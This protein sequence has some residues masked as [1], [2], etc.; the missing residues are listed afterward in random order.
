MRSPV[1]SYD[2][3]PVPGRDGK[4]IGNGMT[5]NWSIGPLKN[6]ITL[7]WTNIAMENHHF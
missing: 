2:I 1:T 4:G 5:Q 3:I 6:W 7:W